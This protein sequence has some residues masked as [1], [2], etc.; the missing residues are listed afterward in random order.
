MD[1]NQVIIASLSQESNLEDLR[2]ALIALLLQAQD[3]EATD[4]YT[5]GLVTAWLDG[6]NAEDVSD[7][8]PTQFVLMVLDD[9]TDN[10][11][12]NILNESGSQLS[13][14]DKIREFDTEKVI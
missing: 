9:F 14:A 6:R 4:K 7:P 8:D 12:I 2:S 13:D 1:L 10:Q 3:F 5:F 11:K